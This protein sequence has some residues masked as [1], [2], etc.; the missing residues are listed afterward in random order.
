MHEP[1]PAPSASDDPAPADRGPAWPARLIDVGRRLSRSGRPTDEGPLLGELWCLLTTAL[2][3]RV[4]AEARRT[5]TIGPEDTEDLVAEKS[6]EI[7]RKIDEGK[8]DLAGS[9]PPEVMR[10]LSTVARNGLVDHL[11]RTNRSPMVSGEPDDAS[12]ATDAAAEAAASADTAALRGEFVQ[13]LVRC[14]D[15][16]SPEHRRIWFLRVFHEMPSR[17]IASHPEVQ[18]TVG[19]VD[20]IQQRCRRQVRTCMEKS[21]FDPGDIPPGTFAALWRAFRMEV[22]DA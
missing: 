7:A 9:S 11:R 1:R 3:Q 6:L 19:H 16:L 21:G 12:R 8:W 13:A 2:R 10:F 5:G 17:H 22:R 20:V 18:R 4:G 15:R 14:A